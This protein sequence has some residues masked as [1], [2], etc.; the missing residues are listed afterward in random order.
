MEHLPMFKK[1]VENNT[2]FVSC[3][4]LPTLHHFARISKRSKP[5]PKQNAT[6]SFLRGE[7]SSKRDGDVQR[8]AVL[9]RTHF[10]IERWCWRVT[11]VV[12]PLT[13][14]SWILISTHCCVFKH[15]AEYGTYSPVCVVVDKKCLFVHV[16]VWVFKYIRRPL[17]L[18]VPSFPYL[19]APDLSL[20]HT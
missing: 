20:C 17:H 8:E 11:S 16:C 12:R 9:V 6:S 2:L 1:H 13:S 3:Q 15:E 18:A 4:F 19:L 10:D 5:Y 7:S 14:N